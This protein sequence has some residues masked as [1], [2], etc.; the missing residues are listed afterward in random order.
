[1]RRP[2]ASAT[3]A[4]NTGPLTDPVFAKR[5]PTLFAYLTDD[6]WED[7]AERETS[8]MLVMVDGGIY[9][10]WLNDRALRRSLWA[11]GATLQG[12]MDALNAA[13]EDE[14]AGWRATQQREPKKGGKKG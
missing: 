8:T 1:M 11:A 14:K 12:L 4:S 3:G 6:M 2:A 5:C 10:A 13:L 9:K 7:G